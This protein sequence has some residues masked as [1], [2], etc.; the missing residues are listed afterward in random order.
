MT[1]LYFPASVAVESFNHNGT[2]F[3]KAQNIDE[4]QT[5]LST[6]VTP[7]PSDYVDFFRMDG[8]PTENNT[9]EF[10]FVDEG[11]D[12]FHEVIDLYFKTLQKN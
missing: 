7:K 3:V 2:I 9:D 4:A 11:A 1:Q 8:L 10:L 6:L 5:K 12:S